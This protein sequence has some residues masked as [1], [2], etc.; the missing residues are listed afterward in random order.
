MVTTL[1]QREIN[2]ALLES[3]AA[4]PERSKELVAELD[5]IFGDGLNQ[6]LGSL[7]NRL[8][9]IRTDGK[10]ETP[11]RLVRKLRKDGQYKKELNRILLYL[12]IRLEK[13]I[14][15]MQSRA[16]KEA[17]RA[18]TRIWNTNTPKGV[19]VESEVKRG[20]LERIQG[21][22][23]NG[24]MLREW[25]DQHMNY[26]F[27]RVLAVSTLFVVRETGD[28]DGKRI[29]GKRLKGAVDRAASELKAVAAQAINLANNLAYEDENNLFLDREQWRYQ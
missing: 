15:A 2:I 3:H 17:L 21:M 9:A 20:D 11:L 7:M 10:G 6:L 18:I 19:K 14:R 29:L 16:Y 12:A 4:L 23:L 13:R 27:T 1:K 8:D 26:I 28:E 22:P 5:P 24:L 25:I